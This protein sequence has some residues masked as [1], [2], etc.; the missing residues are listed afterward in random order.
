MAWVRPCAESAKLLAR[1]GEHFP[2]ECPACGGAIQLISFIAE[3]GPIRRILT[4][5]GQ[6]LEP[7]PLTP[8]RGPPIDWA[9]LA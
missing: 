5:L 1:I 7:P 2:P 9:E 6:P 3:P 4:H 8:A